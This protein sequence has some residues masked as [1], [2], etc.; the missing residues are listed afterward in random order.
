MLHANK[1]SMWNF[2]FDQFLLIFSISEVT[3]FLKMNKKNKKS[4]AVS[5]RCAFAL[6]TVSRQIVQ[7]D[8]FF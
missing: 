7:K 1:Y 4:N 3:L 5:N 2:M 8:F 6:P